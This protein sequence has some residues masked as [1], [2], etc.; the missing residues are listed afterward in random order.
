MVKKYYG[1]WKP[2]YVPPQIPVEPEQTA[3]RTAK[4]SF[5]GRTLPI[6]TLAYKSM[7][8]HPDS[9]A[10][11]AALLLGDL[12][13]GETSE[14]HK[15]LVLEEQRVQFVGGDFGFSRDPNLFSITAMVVDS[16]DIGGIQQEIEKTIAQYQSTPV[17]EARLKDVKSNTRYGFLMRLETPGDVAGRLISSLT[18]TGNMDNVDR[19]YATLDRVTPNDVMAAAQRFLVKDKRT[20]VLVEGQ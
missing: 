16:N 18:L 17:D 8:F 14:I 19:F 4:V 15:K 6:L 3:E 12:A 2:G 20:I 13:F 5:E 11:A 1:E 9:I 10:P 7:A